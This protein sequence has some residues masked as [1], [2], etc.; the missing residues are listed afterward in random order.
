MG[1][2]NTAFMKRLFLQLGGIIAVAVILA[3]FLL[4]YHSTYSTVVTLDREADGRWAGITHDLVERYQGIP[5]LAA[6]LG[7][8]L[9]PDTPTLDEVSRNL[10]RWNTALREG[11]IGKLDPETANLE[12]ALS[13]FV[14]VLEG[15]PDLRESREV[16]L[17]LQELDHS[18]AVAEADRAAFNQVIQDYNEAIGSFP[19]TLWSENWGYVRRA[20]FTAEI[21]ERGTSPEPSS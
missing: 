3:G 19:A 20:S 15:R 5:S 13:R 7:P 1:P 10:S 16:M 14:R 12:A 18:G 2:S 6:F 8:S 11:G 4:A 17:F 21:G 9:G